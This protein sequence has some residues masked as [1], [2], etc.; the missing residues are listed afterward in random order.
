MEGI[1][2]YISR[3]VKKLYESELKM[4]LENEYTGLPIIQL[5]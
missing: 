3:M 4:Q 1:Y 2:Y 5:K